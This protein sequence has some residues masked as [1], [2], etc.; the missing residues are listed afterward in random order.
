MSPNEIRDKPHFVQDAPMRERNAQREWIAGGDALIGE[1]SDE[2]V[3]V[4]E[5]HVG[6]SAGR[7]LQPDREVHDLE[8][9]LNEWPPGLAVLAA[10]F[11]VGEFDTVAL[12]KQARAAVGE[13]VDHRGGPDRIEVELGAR[14]VDVAG[15]KE[16]QKAVVGAV[17]RAADEGGDVG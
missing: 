4:N 14:A 9:V 15:M 10:P 5:L 1:G 3:G 2:L 11:D 7:A 8:L 13:R 12:Y 6:A 17:E 16:P